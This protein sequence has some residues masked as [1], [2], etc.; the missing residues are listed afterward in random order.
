SSDA[1]FAN[2]AE[3]SRLFGRVRTGR[4]GVKGGWRVYSSGPGIFINQVISNVLGL[5]TYFDDVVIDP[6]LP[7]CAN[8]LTFDSAYDGQRVRYLY[9][10][11]G[12]GFGPR[13]VRVNDR[14][15]S[16]TTSADNPYRRG[17]LH[18]PKHVFRESL[19]RDE[20]LVEV[21]I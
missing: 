15:L 18:V 16:G 19:D 2:R 21:Y 14:P 13:D 20:N 5:R 7:R 9:H 3:A 8:G 4:V 12:D 10:V 17:G 11:S 1:A 6:V